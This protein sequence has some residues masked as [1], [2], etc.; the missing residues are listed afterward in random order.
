VGAPAGELDEEEDV[1]PL[2]RDGLD[3]EEIDRD[4][5]LGLRS[6]KGTPGESGTNTWLMSCRISRNELDTWQ[7][8]RARQTKQP[9]TRS[10]AQ[11]RSLRA[12][13]HKMQRRTCSERPL[14]LLL[15]LHRVTRAGG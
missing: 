4:H 5:A 13:A 15:P 9:P 6:Q 2:Q 8:P 11:Q 3:G 12:A 14:A 1:Q 7:T 10:N